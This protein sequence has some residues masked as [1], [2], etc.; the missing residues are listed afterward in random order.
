MRELILVL[1][2]LIAKSKD[3]T[4]TFVDWLR[5]ADAVIHLLLDSQMG[6]GETHSV[7]EELELREVAAELMGE[8]GGGANLGVA[9]SI[10]LRIL[11]GYLVNQFLDKASEESSDDASA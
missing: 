10:F 1:R 5:A 2:E 8:P 4:A 7:E 11:L 6:F 9:G 3:G